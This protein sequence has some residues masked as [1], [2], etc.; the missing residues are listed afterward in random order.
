MFRTGFMNAD[1]AWR[2][3]ALVSGLVLM[4]A[5]LPYLQTARYGFIGIDDDDYIAQNAM[6]N[7][8]LTAPN[9]ARAWTSVGYAANWHPLTWMSLMTDVSLFGV[10]PGA[11]HLHNAMLHGLNA[12]AFF[13]LMLLWARDVHHEERAGPAICFSAAAA[14]VLWSGHPL[15][16]EAV[17]WI[18]ERKELLAV[19]WCLATLLLQ[20]HG[21]RRGSFQGWIYVMSIVA[22]LLA[23]SAKPVA[24]SLPAVML[25]N[26]WWR[27]GR[28][29][30]W[31][32]LPFA[33]LAASCSALTLLAQRE[34][35][36]PTE[37][38]GAQA[39]L[40]NAVQA[41]GDR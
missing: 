35:M 17:A 14:A 30:W 12:V 3:V 36:A 16:V 33:A 31:R 4:I 20:T 2:R 9:T 40:V 32:W 21:L 22:Y 23:V 18:T 34:A 6:V 26:E 25:A 13:L 39:R 7:S 10:R 28:I 41:V 19:F 29:R 1:V 38:V 15:R 8:G 24:V 27:T 5:V 37:M 11:M